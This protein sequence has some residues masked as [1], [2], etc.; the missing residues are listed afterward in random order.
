MIV[1]HSVLKIFPLHPQALSRSKAIFILE[2][3][4]G[5]YIAVI[6]FDCKTIINN[7]GIRIFNTKYHGHTRSNIKEP[8]LCATLPDGHR[9]YAASLDTGKR[10]KEVLTLLAFGEPFVSGWL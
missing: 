2:D 1:L 5:A 4:L 9:S 10:A 8:S 3:E 6:A 7:A